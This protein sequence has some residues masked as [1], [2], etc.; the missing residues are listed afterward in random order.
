MQRRCKP[1]TDRKSHS[2]VNE[3]AS[4]KHLVESTE[5]FMREKKCAILQT[6]GIFQPQAGTTE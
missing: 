6:T 2:K 5:I 4:N 3:A 1:F